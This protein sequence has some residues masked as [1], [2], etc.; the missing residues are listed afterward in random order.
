[1]SFVRTS[2]NF[3]TSGSATFLTSTLRLL[4]FGVTLVG[5]LLMVVFVPETVKPHMAHEQ[6]QR[7]LQ[8]TLKLTFSLQVLSMVTAVVVYVYLLEPKIHRLM[9]ILVVMMNDVMT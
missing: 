9:V 8:R 7:R 1:M 4:S 5:F 2:I 6:K 3:T